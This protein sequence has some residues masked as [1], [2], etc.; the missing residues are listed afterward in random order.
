MWGSLSVLCFK[1]QRFT[2]EGWLPRTALP[3]LVKVHYIQIKEMKEYE[4]F[5]V[6]VNSLSPVFAR[7]G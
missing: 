2:E 6:A 5:V 4:G 3:M 1:A 7:Y